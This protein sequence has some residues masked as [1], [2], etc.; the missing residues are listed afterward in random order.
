MPATLGFLV[1][2]FLGFLVSWF[3]GFLGSF[4]NRQ[5]DMASNTSD[6]Q[7]LDTLEGDDIKYGELEEFKSKP[8]L[9]QGEQRG[10]M[11]RRG[12]MTV[13]RGWVWN[14][15]RGT[16]SSSHWRAYR[17]DHYTA[18]YQITPPPR[19]RGHTDPRRQPFVK[20]KP[21]PEGRRLNFIRHGN[22]NM[23]INTTQKPS[24]HYYW[25]GPG[26]PAPIPLYTAE[27]QITPPPFGRGR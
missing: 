14:G 18:E 6:Q 12:G 22:K 15:P 10:W 24:T 7:E 11:F 13:N 26:A 17:K 19:G 25:I 23:T 2:W 20:I 1:S 16:D 9:I 27:Y 3:L 4:P 8:G 5:V 21:P